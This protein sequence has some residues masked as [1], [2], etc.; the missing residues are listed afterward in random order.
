MSSYTPRPAYA[1]SFLSRIGFSY[2]PPDFRNPSQLIRVT[3][4]AILREC[5]L[6]NFFYLLEN[7]LLFARDVI[8]LSQELVP[9]SFLPLSIEGPPILF[10]RDNWFLRLDEE[11]PSGSTRRPLRFSNSSLVLLGMASPNVTEGNPLILPQFF[12][13]HVALS[14][15]AFPD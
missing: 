11:S 10:G 15:V 1:R 12:P 14:V 13:G 3:P 6:S 8:V 5:S 2:A 9:F 4:S 7:F